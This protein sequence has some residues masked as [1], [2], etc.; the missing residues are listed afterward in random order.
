MAQT[1]SICTLIKADEP[2][3]QLYG[4]ITIVDSVGDNARTCSA[5]T[6]DQL[7]TRP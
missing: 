4:H 7:M 2:A 6:A 5:V 3:C 1:R